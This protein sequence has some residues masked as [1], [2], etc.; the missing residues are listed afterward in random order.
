MCAE[1]EVVRKL[2]DSDLA[3]GGGDGKLKFAVR[4]AVSFDVGVDPALHVI[5]PQ[6]PVGVGKGGL[7]F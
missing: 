4:L 5:V 3:S 7:D 6:R 1:N 2:F